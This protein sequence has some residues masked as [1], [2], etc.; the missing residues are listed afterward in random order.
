[1]PEFTYIY[2]QTF[3]AGLK[4]ASPL[5]VLLALLILLLGILVGLRESWGR[6]D[7]I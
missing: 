7:S 3:Y 1:M 6:Y 5:L 2:L 4:L